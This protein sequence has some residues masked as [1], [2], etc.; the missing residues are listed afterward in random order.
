MKF[1]S[2]IYK[3]MLPTTVSI[4]RDKLTQV[5]LTEEEKNEVD[6]KRNMLLALIS[7]V[8]VFLVLVAVRYTFGSY[9]TEA[10]EWIVDGFGYPG[11]F[12]SVLFMDTFI[13]IISPDVILFIAVAGDVNVYGA[14]ITV[15]CASLI[16]GNFGYLIG[17]FLSHRKWVQKKIKPFEKKGHYLM[18]KY[19]ILAMIAGAMTPVPFSAVCWTAGMLEMK[20]THFLAGLIW[21]VPHYLL[22]YIILRSSFIG[23]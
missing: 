12:L 6:P 5:D 9:I 13:V 14:L 7:F 8:V 23:I 4:N 18:G 15:I 21:R 3:A 1:T 16:G 11:I 17:R 20:Y 2:V 10:G 19:G 22:W